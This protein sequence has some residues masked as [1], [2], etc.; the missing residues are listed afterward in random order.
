M[1][2]SIPRPSL[3][4]LPPLSRQ[5]DFRIDYGRDLEPSVDELA[6]RISADPTLVAAYAP[7]WLAVK[8]LEGEVD[9]IERVRATPHGSVLIDAAEAARARIEAR[10]GDSAEIAIADARY[11]FIHDVV[12]EVLDASAA[13]RRT[14][15][16]RLDR[17]LTH[18]LFGLPIFFA[19]MLIVFKLVVEVSGYFL[20][21]V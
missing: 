14:R 6:R 11:G 3:G 19:V 4:L 13:T 2:V 1:T 17:V 9:V 18:R 12:R 21:W 15:T 16:D 10:Y 8:L 5:R 20:E 7:R